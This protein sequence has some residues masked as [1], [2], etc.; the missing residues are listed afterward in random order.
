MSQAPSMPMFWDAYL[1]DTTHLS[2]EEHGAYLLLL[3]AMWRR[4]GWVPDDDR[5]NARILGL[6][7]AK[8]RRVKDRLRPLLVFEEDHITQKNLLKIWKITQEKI[9]KNRENGA[10]GGRPKCNKNNGKPKANGSVSQN[11]NKTIPE[12]EPYKRDTDVSLAPSRFEEF[13]AVYPHRHGVKKGKK[14]SRQKYAAAVKRG[15]SEQTIIDAAL[16][17]QADRRVL[18]GYAKDPPTWLNQECW[19]D[20]IDATKGADHARARHNRDGQGIAIAERAAQRWAEK[21]R[22]RGLDSRE[23][24]DTVVPLLPARSSAG[25]C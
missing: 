18:D 23:G 8:W 7:P 10:K 2:T 4:N 19:E 17:Y 22:A 6:T 3:A 25:S 15:V 14:P 11:P 20:E 12:P 21:Q 9:D 24:T 13:W 1:A 16:K 5:D